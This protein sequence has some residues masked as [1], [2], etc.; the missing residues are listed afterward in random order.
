MVF[1]TKQYRCPI[2]GG[3]I[4][5]PKHHNGRPLKYCDQCHPHVVVYNRRFGV[6]AKQLP[7]FEY[8]RKER[9][10]P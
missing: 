1:P 9:G 10:T 7:L 3:D 2:C 6:L 5:H 4:P 8:V